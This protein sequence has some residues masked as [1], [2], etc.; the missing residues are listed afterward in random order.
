MQCRTWTNPEGD[1]AAFGSAS[2]G[3]CV[4]WGGPGCCLIS[5]C[6]SAGSLGLPSAAIGAGLAGSTLTHPQ[7]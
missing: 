7:M 6:G 1:G 4:G 3:E 2:F 5:A